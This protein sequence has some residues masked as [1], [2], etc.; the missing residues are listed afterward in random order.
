VVLIDEST[1]GGVS[2][3]RLAGPILDDSAIVGCALAEAAVGPV[4][5]VCSAYSRRSCSSC[6]RFHTR[7]RSGSSRRIVATHRSAYE[8]ATG[9]RGVRIVVV[10]SLRNTSSNAL[11]NWPARAQLLAGNAI[12][13]YR[14]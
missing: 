11:M 4:G 12:R 9:V 5:V 3:E 10:L 14:L 13:N 7:V 2:S 8:F 6:R 1:A